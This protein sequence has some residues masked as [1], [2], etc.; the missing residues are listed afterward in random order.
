MQCGLAAE[1]WEHQSV[2]TPTDPHLSGLLEQKRDWM[3]LIS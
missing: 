2:S 1:D 3:Q